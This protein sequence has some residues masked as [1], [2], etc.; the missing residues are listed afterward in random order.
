MAG[1]S[2]LGR[3]LM[4]SS[5]A[6]PTPDFK[7]GV[8]VHEHSISLKEQRSARARNLEDIKSRTGGSLIPE[9]MKHIE[10]D[11]EHAFTAENL[12]KLGQVPPCGLPD[13]RPPDLVFD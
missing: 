9:S 10:E 11:E 2:R 1:A 7:T 5:S 3:R 12:R 13:T 6:A 8:N 4:G